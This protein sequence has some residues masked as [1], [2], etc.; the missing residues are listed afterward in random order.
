M[1]ETKYIQYEMP[2]GLGAV[3]VVIKD[4]TL[5]CTQKAMAQI[6]GVGVPAISKHLKNIYAEGELTTD[7]TISK[8]ETVVNRG[9][10][11]YVNEMIDFYSLDAIIAVGYR[12][13][14]LKAT[15]FRQWATKILNE[16]IKKG[17]AMD[18][19]RLKRLGG[20]GY[21]KELLTRIRDIRSTEKVFYR[22]VLEIY[23]TSIDY[24]PKASVSQEF[25]KKV[26]NKI[27]YAVHG[28]TAA[29]LIVQ[30]ADAEKDFM[31]LL[32]FKGTQPT[33]EEARTA[34][35]YLNEKEL[36]AMGQLV[37]GYLDFAERQA[38]REQPMTMDDWARYLDGILT[39]TGEKLLQGAGR[40]SHSQAME[41]ATTEYRKY[42]QRVI[43]DAEQDYLDTIRYINDL[44]KKD[45]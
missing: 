33:L 25:F 40:I 34:K 24:D 45:K 23:A 30:R 44:N 9:V 22:Q 18:D 42:K 2:N 37:S 41:H 29:E 19:D 6:F 27:H 10:R 4:E 17:F 15:R 21:W 13:S 1:D 31:G 7:T 38:E 16:Y 35:N 12:V 5:W 3:E 32:S 39:M 20:G 28:N 26:Q 43:S 11:G 14:S 8:M 36:R